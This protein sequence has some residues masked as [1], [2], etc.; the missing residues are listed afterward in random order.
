M[1]LND[2]CC[3]PLCCNSVLYAERHYPEFRH[4]ECRDA[5]SD[6]LTKQARILTVFYGL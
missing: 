1:T 2:A 5:I 4:A 6:I 3:Y